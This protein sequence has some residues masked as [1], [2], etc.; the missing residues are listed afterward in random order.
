MGRK[1]KRT[2]EVE[3]HSYQKAGVESIYLFN[4]FKYR[5]ESQAFAHSEIQSNVLSFIGG[6]AGAAKTFVAVADAVQQLRSN[7]VDK[8]LLS[9]PTVEAGQ[10][11]GFLPGDFKEKTDPYL[12]PI[13]DILE[14]FLG[15]DQMEAL[16]EEEII[17]VVPLQLMRGRTFNRTYIILDEAQNATKDQL[18]LALT[19]IGDKSRCVVTFDGAQIDVRPLRN[20]CIDHIQEFKGRDKIG[21]FEFTHKD[22][23]RSAIVAQILG[24]YSEIEA[25]E[26]G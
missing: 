4:E 2:H 9:R 21:F 24:V 10:S 15:K 6:P 26:N 12:L 20:S 17:H 5:N 8:I 14:Y 22:I 18:R 13:Y 16:I 3:K 19:R 7:R 11:L 1:H 23:V 25:R